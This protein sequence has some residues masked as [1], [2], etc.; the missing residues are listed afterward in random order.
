MLYVLWYIQKNNYDM[1]EIQFMKG[2]TLLDALHNF[3]N[4]SDFFD[5]IGDDIDISKDELQYFKKVIEFIKDEGSD[6]YSDYIFKFY[7]YDGSCY[8][9]EIKLEQ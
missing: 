9:K 4:E 6:G 1:S 5:F 7:K 8:G 3:I 2:K